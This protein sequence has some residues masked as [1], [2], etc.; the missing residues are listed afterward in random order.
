M[1]KHLASCAPRHDPRRGESADLCLFRVES[2]GARMYWIDVEA[3][4]ASPIRGLDGLLRRVWLECCGHMSAFEIG[5]QRYSVHVDRGSP[6]ATSERSMSADIA[7]V[8]TSPGHRFSYE[9]DFGSTTQLALRFIGVRRGIV[10]RTPARLL[11]RNE[12]PIWPCAVCD[13]PATL[14]CPFCVG[15]RNPFVCRRHVRGHP[16]DD[17]ESFLPVV[18]SPRMGVCGYTGEE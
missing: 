11:A 6:F 15:E 7:E 18:N 13:A 17:E 1:L 8:L 16:C 12:P 3:K 14:I 10:G 5:G 4:A 2:P 9:Y